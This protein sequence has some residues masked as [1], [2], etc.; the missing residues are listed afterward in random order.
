MRRSLQR[1]YLLLET[2]RKVGCFMFYE[3][4]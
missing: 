3:E 4:I 2:S 1:Q